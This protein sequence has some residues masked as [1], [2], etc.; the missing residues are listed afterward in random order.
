MFMLGRRDKSCAE[1]F[2]NGAGAF[3]ALRAISGHSGPIIMRNFTSA[4]LLDYT[5]LPYIYYG[6]SKEAA[7]QTLVGGILAG[8]PDLSRRDKRH[9]AFYSGA[10]PCPE[11]TDKSIRRP[12]N[13][14]TSTRRLSSSS[15]LMGFE[16]TT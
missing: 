3:I 7:R 2:V 8:G 13:P 14:I 15:A 4:K 6:T 5:Y 16:G 12:W 10:R 9:D 11:I 1:Y